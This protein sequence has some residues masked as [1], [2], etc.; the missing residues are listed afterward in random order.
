[1]ISEQKLDSTI[2]VKPTVLGALLD[3]AK[4]TE[5]MLAILR[6]AQAHNVGIEIATETRDLVEY[7]LETAV[8]IT[9]EGSVVTLALQAYLNRTL[10]DIKVAF[11]NGFKIRLVKEAYVGDIENYVYIQQQFKKSIEVVME[12]KQPILVGTH[13]PEIIDWVKKRLDL[14]KKLVEFSF[15]KGLSDITKV[16][17]SKQGWN[18]L[19]YVPYGEKV[20]AYENRRLRFLKELERMGKT[21]AP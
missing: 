1:V 6:A 21:S 3:K 19:E 10:E 18:V 12:N 2:T 9:K 5:K 16:E 15:L 14:D 17:L 7:A 8:M 20:D 11:K 4:C 13:D